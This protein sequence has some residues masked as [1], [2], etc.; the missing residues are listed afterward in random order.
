MVAIACCKIS[1]HATTT[2]KHFVYKRDTKKKH[3]EKMQGAEAARRLHLPQL[4]A[5]RQQRGT[6]PGAPV[7]R[8]QRRRRRK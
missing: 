8:V 1:F 6:H 7:L 5:A 2:T 3:F 4:A